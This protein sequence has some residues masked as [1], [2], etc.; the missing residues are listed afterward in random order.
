MLSHPKQGFSLVEAVLASFLLLTALAMSVYVF[1]SSLQAEANNEKRVAAA[2]VAESALAEIRQQANTNFNQVKTS[3]HNKTWTLPG[4]AEFVIRAKIDNTELAVP[5]TEL[6]SQYD[7]AATFPNPSGRYLSDSALKAE[8]EITW[9]TSGR[10]R[11]TVTENVVNFAKATNF[12]VDVI[13]PDGTA[14]TGSTVLNLAQDATE[15]FTARARSGGQNVKDIQFTWYVQPVTGFGSLLH[16]SRDGEEA[17]YINAYRN[18]KNK[19]KHEPGDCFLVV[20]ATYQGLEQEGKV[21][22]VNGG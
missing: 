14:A 13:L 22:I 8:V 16:V 15:Q 5:C 19:W 2:L 4:Y 1:D 3:F 6:E 10:D 21:R 11:I 9:G 12:N 20:R 17:E 7:P 18:F